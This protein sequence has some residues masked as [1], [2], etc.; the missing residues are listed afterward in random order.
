MAGAALR[1]VN[2]AID[3]H[4]ATAKIGKL[5]EQSLQTLFMIG[6]VDQRGRGDGAGIDHRIERPVAAFVEDN[7]VKRFAAGLD[8][9]FL[10][11]LFDAPVFQGKR[12]NE[13]L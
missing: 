2:R 5:A 4:R 9:D 12:V 10:Q 1:S 11:N 6:A 8:T 13:R 7:R 3:L